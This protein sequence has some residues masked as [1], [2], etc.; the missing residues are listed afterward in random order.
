[1][2]ETNV[3]DVQ[4]QNLGEEKKENETP[5]PAEAKKE[6]PMKKEPLWKK[7][8]KW[9]GIG[10][11]GALAIGGAFLLGGKV[12]GKKRY[13]D[14]PSRPAEIPAY[15]EEPGSDSVPYA[16]DADFVEVEE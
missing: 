14:V 12:G 2:A 8:L 16:E 6:E 1:M 13:S 5:Q 11:G 10:V 7:I 4:N 3:K 9:G 15:P